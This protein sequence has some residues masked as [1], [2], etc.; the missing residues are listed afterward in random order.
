MMYHMNNF[1]S[2]RA[3]RAA[4]AVVNMREYRKESERAAKLT[5]KLSATLTPEQRRLWDELDAN[6]G[7][8]AS[9]IN[10]EAYKTGLLAG[11]ALGHISATHRRKVDKAGKE[12]FRLGYAEGRR[13]AMA[14][15][16]HDCEEPPRKS[17]RTPV[18]APET[19]K[20]GMNTP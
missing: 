8:R 20:T 9:I 3:S 18:S 1:Y 5:E 17:R 16:A 7:A 10:R 4:S 14:I 13:A 12:M 11:L 15:R 2:K 6:D 19:D